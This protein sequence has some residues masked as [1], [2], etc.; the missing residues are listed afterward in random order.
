MA[1]FLLVLDD[2]EAHQNDRLWLDPHLAVS[3]IDIALR[4]EKLGFGDN[5]RRHVT[6][7]LRSAAIRSLHD[8]AVACGL[9]ADVI[10][11]YLLFATASDKEG[12]AAAA[13]K[14]YAA[15]TK[16]LGKSHLNHRYA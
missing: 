8:I 1:Q 5:L 6:L 4:A 15:L 12:N 7:I 10:S 16:G 14:V 13:R 9:G 11:P 3:K 2:A